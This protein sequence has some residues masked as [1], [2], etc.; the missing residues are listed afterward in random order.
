[1]TK[2]TIRIGSGAGFS[3]DRID[4]AIELLEQGELDY[5]AFECLAERTIALAQLARRTDPAAGF[6]PL[7]EA[8]MR[9]ALPAAS[10]RRV[11]II[12]NMGAA[13]PVEAAR[14]TAH[15]AA[16]LGLH[17]L[18]IAAVTGDDVLDWIAGRDL[19]FIDRASGTAS[20]G[21][22][23][24]SANVYLGAEAI[25]RALAEGADVVITGRVGD[26]ALFVAPMIHA[27]GW[28]P[29]DWQRLGR[30]TIVGH[31]LECAGQLTGGYFAD[32]GVK[33][34]PDLAR[35]GFPF[36]D[37]DADGDATFGKVAGSG[38]RLD[39]ATCTEQ[40]L[41]EILDPAAYLQADVTADLSRV[42]LEQA[43][44]D[45]VRVT[46][47]SGHARP[48]ELKASIGYRDGYIGEGQMSYA[49]PGAV[50]RGQLAIDVLRERFAL[51]G[52][53]VE[54]L[55]CDLIGINAV[56][57]TAPTAAEPAEVRVRVAGRT[58]TAADAHRIGAEVE[59]LY[60]NGPAGGGG[61]TKAVREVLAVAS[62]LVPRDAVRPEIRWFPE[63]AI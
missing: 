51:T 49:G 28:V 37:V 15:I 63:A 50:A 32:P 56:A 23:I 38:G 35:L 40:L 9:A 12:T 52:L 18:R 2:R 8:R 6:D 14:A 43:G 21:N 16:E 39:V 17:G 58:R 45:R 26:P 47:G 48:A 53:A 22:A 41:Y 61:A 13:N 60:T 34:V 33:D 1:M 20:L 24:V 5:I 31:L 29:G 11:P 3:G 62:V 25:A 19:P 30:G 42:V 57:Q 44:P 10:A 46:G 36:A 55:R 4:P 54:E 27:F 59:A 7:L